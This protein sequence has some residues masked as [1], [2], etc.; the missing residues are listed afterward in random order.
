MSR[1]IRLDK[2]DPIEWTVIFNKGY[3][4]WT[5]SAAHRSGLSQRYQ[6]QLAQL[7]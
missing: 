2:M 4:G 7:L 1:N 3:F 5:L 6:G